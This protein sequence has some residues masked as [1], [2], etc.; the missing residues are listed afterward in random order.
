M[1]P[2]LATPFGQD[3]LRSAVEAAETVSAGAKT[4][5]DLREALRAE[6]L[7]LWYQPKLELRSFTLQG[8]EALLRLRH[9]VDGFIGPDRIIPHA[10]RQDLLDVS[11]F[12]IT[13]A[14]ADWQWFVDNHGPLEIA[15]NLPLA[16]LRDPDCIADFICRIPAHPAFDG[17]IVETDAS[18]LVRDLDTV[19]GTARTLSPRRVALSVDD[20]DAEW[21]EILDFAHD[22]PF[23]EIK[24]DRSLVANCC[25]DSRK[26]SACSRIVE[27]AD[28]VGARTVAEGVQTRAEFIAVRELGFDAVQGYFVAKPMPRGRFLSRVLHQPMTLAGMYA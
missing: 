7:E 16:Y 1:L 14:F 27:F 28:A 5:V 10:S 13:R 15:I 17:L 8:A 11:T 21:P 23:A 2:F 12:V 26:R 6:W 25:D 9:P 3:A 22:F 19:K 18:E 20:L 24:V 4:S